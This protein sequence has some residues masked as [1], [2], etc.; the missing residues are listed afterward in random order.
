MKKPRTDKV[1]RQDAIRQRRLRANRKARKAALG[2]EKIKLEAYAGTRADIEAVRMVG[3]FD[4]EA[5]AITLGLR[6]LGNMARRSP[7]KF[8]NAIEP[9]NLV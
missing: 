7:A 1:R 4:D 8:R 2:A 9:R 3:G 5:E 6:L